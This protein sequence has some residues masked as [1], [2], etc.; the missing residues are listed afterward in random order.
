MLIY[1]ATE[2]QMYA[3]TKG[4]DLQMAIIIYHG[5]EKILEKPICGKGASTNDY[6]RGFY[7]TQELEL[8]KEWALDILW[9]KQ[10]ANLPKKY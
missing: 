5:S 8:A 9:A 7:C 10:G 2:I 3:V 4:R 6:R 1:I